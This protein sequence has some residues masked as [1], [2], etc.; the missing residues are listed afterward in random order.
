VTVL[1][2]EHDIQLG[3]DEGSRGPTATRRRP[4]AG[5]LFLPVYSLRLKWGSFA[6]R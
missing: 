2:I 5:C 1:L 3:A 4:P 6:L